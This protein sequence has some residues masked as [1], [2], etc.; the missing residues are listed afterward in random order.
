MKKPLLTV[1]SALVLSACATTPPAD[2]PVLVKLAD[3]ERRLQGIERVVQN[4]SLVKLTQQVNAA[5]RRGDEM[6]GR[7]EELEYRSE[8]A[9]DRQRQLYVDLDTR[10][11]ELEASVQA[12]NAP[13]GR[14]QGQLPVPS[15][16]DRD[17][18]QAAFELLKE[19]NLT[20]S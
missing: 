19:Q 4:Q 12:Q 20:V 17:N 6:L 1:V 16:S 2:D 10:M 9:L 8:S 13:G 7:V 5:E 3:L 18:Y 11:Q 15:G 14:T